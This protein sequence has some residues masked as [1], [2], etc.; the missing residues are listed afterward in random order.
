MRKN[1]SQV[2]GSLLEDFDEKKYERTIRQESYD[3]GY[4]S[5]YGTGKDDGIEEERQ[6]LLCNLMKNMGLTEEEARGKLGL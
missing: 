5:G 3:E 4:D 1:R 2:L 6:I